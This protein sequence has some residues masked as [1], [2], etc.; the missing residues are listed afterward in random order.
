M[1]KDIWIRV[2]VMSHKNPVQMVVMSH[3]QVVVISRGQVALSTYFLP[4]PH[5]LANPMKAF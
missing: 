5:F 3:A 2:V 1:K 4:V